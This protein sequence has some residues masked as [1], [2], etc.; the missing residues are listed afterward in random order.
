[1]ILQRAAL[2]ASGIDHRLGVGPRPLRR[3]SVALRPGA[4][5]PK[6]RDATIVVQVGINPDPILGSRLHFRTNAGEAEGRISALLKKARHGDPLNAAPNPEPSVRFGFALR[7]GE[8][9]NHEAVGSGERMR[10]LAPRDPRQR[11]VDV[12]RAVTASK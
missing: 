2:S 1:M 3:P 5:D 10:L 4:L 6:R 9:R 7:P 12:A 11:E 8:A